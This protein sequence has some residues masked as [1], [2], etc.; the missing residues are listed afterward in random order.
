ME[1][2]RRPWKTV[3][4]VKG[5]PGSDRGKAKRSLRLLVLLRYDLRSCGKLLPARK[6]TAPSWIV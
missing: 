2:F 1:A 6:V 5:F 4:F 3:S